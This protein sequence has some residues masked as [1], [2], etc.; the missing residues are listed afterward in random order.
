[1]ASEKT[2]HSICRW[3]FYPSEGGSIRGHSIERKELCNIP[4]ISEFIEYLRYTPPLFIE[5]KEQNDFHKHRFLRRFLKKTKIVLGP[6]APWG[7]THARPFFRLYLNYDTRCCFNNNLNFYRILI[8][9]INFTV[10]F[11]VGM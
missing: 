4:I 3:T 8:F 7:I 5:R 9:F 1:M 10:C 2:L 6:L 11:K